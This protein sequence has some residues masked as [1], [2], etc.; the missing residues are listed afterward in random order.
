MPLSFD[1]SPF[2]TEEEHAAYLNLSPAAQA[3]AL[4]AYRIMASNELRHNYYNDP[5]S[6]LYGLSE[7]RF[8]GAAST[9]GAS[10]RSSLSELIDAFIK[11]HHSRTARA[12][13]GYW[14]FD[15]AAR[16]KR[17]LALGV[18]SSMLVPTLATQL[19]LDGMEAPECEDELNDLVEPG[20]AIVL[21]PSVGS[22]GDGL[23]C[24]SV[25]RAPLEHV[26]TA[27]GSPRVQSAESLPAL[28]ADAVW[29]FKPKKSN[30]YPPGSFDPL[31]AQRTWSES[32]ELR[33]YRRCDWF[34]ELILSDVD[35]HGGPTGTLLVEPLVAYDQELCVL[36]V[37][38]GAVQ[39]LAGRANCMER[40]LM[41]EGHAETL[42]AA[43]DF[44]PP[45]C[46]AHVL[47]AP[48]RQR[49]T[50]MVLEQPT[51]TDP[52]RRPLHEAIRQ[53]VARLGAATRLAA[54]RVDCFVRW[55]AAGGDGDTGG[56]VLLLNEVESGFWA[57]RMLGWFGQPL[58]DYAMRAWALGGDAAQRHAFAAAAAAASS[59]RTQGDGSRWEHGLERSWPPD[60]GAYVHTRIPTLA[61]PSSVWLRSW[62]AR[63]PAGVGALE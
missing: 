18:P 46:R 10:Y 26:P 55:G 7:A 29:V 3:V 31:A 14:S 1:D 12:D 9:E 53:L 22:G 41:L 42:V 44:T 37:N 23:L 47:S 38:G 50:A 33:S 4:H 56:A 20:R 60:H 35:L 15:K 39:V 11:A 16:K 32:E 34:R 36:A 48:E 2:P 51:R 43:S 62:H 63:Q 19:L 61:T 27:S 40:L 5:T 25:D 49:H 21:K 54:F 13:A 28:P 52:Y 57:E 17:W 58:T 59:E 24:V 8:I 6:L 45:S 30:P